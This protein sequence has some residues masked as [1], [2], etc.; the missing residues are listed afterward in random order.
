[1]KRPR[2]K[3]GSIVLLPNEK[4]ELSIT[5]LIRENR[6]AF[7]DKQ[8]IVFSV[9]RYLVTDLS[10][11]AS[12]LYDRAYIAK[13][14]IKGRYDKHIAYFDDAMLEKLIRDQRIIADMDAAVTEHQFEVWFQRDRH[15]RGLCYGDLSVR[16]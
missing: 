12:A 16:S 7:S 5:R 4:R 11:P 9:G 8:A 15:R 10:L 14:S 6:K 3:R 2:R 1:M 13:R